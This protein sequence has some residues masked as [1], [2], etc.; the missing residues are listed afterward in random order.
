MKLVLQIILV[1]FTVL[2]LVGVIGAKREQ[3]RNFFLVAALLL[4]VAIIVT[5]AIL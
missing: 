3:D 1:A 2:Y 5:I 4:T